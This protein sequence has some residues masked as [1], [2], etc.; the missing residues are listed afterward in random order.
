MQQG[1]T[2]RLRAVVK[3]LQDTLMDLKYATVPSVAAVRGMALGGGLEVAL[4]CSR[5][6]AAHESYMGLVEVGVGLWPAGGGLKERAIRSVDDTRAGDPFALL[7]KFFENAAMAKVS[8]SAREALE[9]GYLRQGDVVVM[10]AD[11]VLHV[12]HQQI[13]AMHESAYKPPSRGRHWPASGR[14]GIAN[15]K[16]AMVNML[17]GHFI[18]E[19]DYELG[20]RIADALCGG[21]V[22]PGTEINSDWLLGLEREHFVTLAMNAKTQERVV[23]MLTTGKPLRN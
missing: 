3:T 9:M 15:L 5:I 23:H 16:A 14:T 7:Q 6:V 22:D 19:Y 20:S 2:D 12:A 4:H 10:H 17:E 11:E 8:G 1:D 21:E 13:R 18:S